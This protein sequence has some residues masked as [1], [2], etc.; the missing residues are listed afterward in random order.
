M[1]TEQDIKDKGWEN[2]I[3]QI[4]LGDC[5]TLMKYIPDKSVDLVLTDPPYGIEFRSN[6]RKIKYDKFYGDKYLPLDILEMAIKKAKKAAYIFC[7]WDNLIQLP[8]PTSVLVWVKNNW[9]MGNL[10]H[11]HGRQWEA[12]CFYPQ[13]EHQFIKRIPDVIQAKRTGNVLHP[14][15]KPE[16]VIR[17]ILEANIGDTIL[18]PF[19]G[20][21]TT[22]VAC[23]QLGRKFIGIE[24]E[25]KY[26]EIAERRLAQD[27]LF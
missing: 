12:I 8:K 21:G 7:R 25:P 17:Q 10:L 1:L 27:Y 16:S 15:E 4:W 26:C 9:S 14:T 24:I 23:K 5:L 20:S 13:E 11:E 18:D 19:L 3:N 6:Y 22:A 2:C